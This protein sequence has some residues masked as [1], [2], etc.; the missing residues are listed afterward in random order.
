MNINK[1]I[2]DRVIFDT[3]VGSQS[4]GTNF[5]DSDEDTVAICVPPIEYLYGSKKFEQL[6]YPDKDRTVY[7]IR[8]V[9]G[10]ISN[11]NPNCLDILFSPE[12]CHK[13]ITPYWE[14]IISIRDSF[15]SKK[16]RYTFAGYSHS[17]F[18]RLKSHREFLLNKKVI[19]EPLRSDFDLPEKSIFPQTQLE[20]IVLIAADFFTEEKK[21]FVMDELK[22]VHSDVI[23][24]LIRNNV[25]EEF[26]PAAMDYFRLS[27]KSHIDLIK[28][29]GADIIRDEY[30]KQAENELRYYSARKNWLRY[31]E[32]KKN[33][34]KER[35]ATEE[36]AGFDLKF[37]MHIVRLN[38]MCKEILTTGKVN[39]DRT[40]IDA[41]YL[42]EIRLGKV[43]FEV[44]EEQMLTLDKEMDILYKNSTLPREPDRELIDNVCIE[45]VDEYIRNNK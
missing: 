31:Q 44:I 6:T 42:K 11:G 37:A 18:L 35:A 15:V 39:V 7:D 16:C 9:L 2:E 41:D 5:P 45:V 27:F 30:K 17:Q 34:N 20:A 43:P 13:R 10:L 8:K 3:V 36:Q 32:W 21:E 23:M 25:I 28:S 1:V 22:Q 19:K 24:P 33:R 29:I 40:N 12:R 26:R 4:Y 38:T 14:K